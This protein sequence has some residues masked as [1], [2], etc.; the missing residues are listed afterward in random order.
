MSIR[1]LLETWVS[2]SSS[3]LH[4][5]LIDIDITST[6]RAARKW[7]TQALRDSTDIKER[8]WSM[9]GKSFID[10]DGFERGLM[11]CYRVWTTSS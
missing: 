8:S 5:I 10:D 11:V 1:L 7:R 4:Y 3:L 6:P 2:Y 9:Q